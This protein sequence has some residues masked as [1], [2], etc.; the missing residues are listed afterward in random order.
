MDTTVTANSRRPSNTDY[1][2]LGLRHGA[3]DLRFRCSH[4]RVLDLADLETP[5]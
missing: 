5:P 3:A 4:F 2:H 1:N